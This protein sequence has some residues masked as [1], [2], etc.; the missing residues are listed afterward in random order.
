MRSRTFL[1]GVS[2]ALVMIALFAVL[3]VISPS[4][5][6]CVTNYDHNT[7]HQIVLI[8][9]DLNLLLTCEGAFIDE[10]NNTITALATVVIAA[11]TGTLWYATTAQGRLTRSSI[12]LARD[13]FNATHR[14][15]IRLKH[16]WIAS[17]DGQHFFGRIESGRPI[18]I[19][20]DIVNVGDTYAFIQLIN[21]VVLII[22]VGTRLPQRPPYNEPGIPQHHI[23]GFQLERGITFTYA[24]ATGRILT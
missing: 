17:A 8:G 6:K 14:P 24:I 12:D 23:N 7:L 20:I 10:N 4:Y 16:L 1:V 2:F 3:G 21:F 11:F 9:Y 15:E 18:T 5:Q 19:R 22:P 13:E